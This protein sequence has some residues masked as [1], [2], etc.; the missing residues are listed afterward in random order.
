MAAW[1]S[2]RIAVAPGERDRQR[3]ATAQAPWPMGGLDRI[4]GQGP[5]HAAATQCPLP[6]PTPRLPAITAPPTPDPGVQRLDAQRRFGKANV[7][8]PP[9]R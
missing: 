1:P 9:S 3:G 8:V 2:E 4:P 7:G 6:T 5:A